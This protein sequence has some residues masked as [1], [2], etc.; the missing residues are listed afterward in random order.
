MFGGLGMPELIII[1]LILLFLFGANKLPKIGRSLGTAITEFKTGVATAKKE[2]EKD[3]E[4]ETE[5]DEDA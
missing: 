4:E 5:K 3:S 2:A 1:F